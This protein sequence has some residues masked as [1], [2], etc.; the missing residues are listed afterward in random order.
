MLALLLIGCIHRVEVTSL[1][2]GAV[3]Y[4]KQTQLGDAP[5]TVRIPMFASTE[6]EARMPGYR[7]VTTRLRGVGTMSFV[8]D[9]VFL[10]WR[11]AVGARPKGQVELRLIPEHGP[12]GTWEPD[13]VP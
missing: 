12:V 10:H 6:I 8:S 11:K 13:E 9:F 1:P 5:V 7:T 3:L 4:R 2:A